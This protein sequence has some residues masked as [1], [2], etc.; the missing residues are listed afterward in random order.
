MIHAAQPIIVF[1]FLKFSLIMN[2]HIKF[3]I[4]NLS[5][6][7]STLFEIVVWCLSSSCKNIEDI[8]Q[9]YIFE[10]LQHSRA[11]I[12]RLKNWQQIW[13]EQDREDSNKLI[14][15]KSI[16][17]LNWMMCFLKSDIDLGICFQLFK[18]QTLLVHSA[19]LFI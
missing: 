18:I 4:D 17:W 15:F 8:D 16:C 6:C 14:D 19:E 2:I 13:C 1:S 5:D 3:L 12:K 11:V 9:I 7:L 10:L